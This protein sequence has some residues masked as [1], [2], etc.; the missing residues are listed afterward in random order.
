M[1]A[2]P[3]RWGLTGA[4]Q[5]GLWRRQRRTGS[6]TV[7]DAGWAA[8]LAGMA[9]LYAILGEG[10]LEHRVLVADHGGLAFGRLTS[11]PPKRVGGEEDPRYRELRAPLAR[12]RRRAAPLSRVLPDAGAGRRAPLG[13]AACGR[14][15]RPRWA[16]V[17]RMGGA[18][19]VARRGVARSGRRPATRSAFRRDESHRGA[20][21][22]VGVWR[23]SRHPNY[24]G[25]WLT[26]C[27]YALI[28]LAAP[29]GWVGLLSPALMLYL[30][31]FV[32]GDSA[33]RGAS[34]RLEGRGVPPLP[35]PDQHVRAVAA[36]LRLRW[37]RLATDLEV[38]FRS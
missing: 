22:D 33:A 29:W 15:Q 7:V 11:A 9:I 31:L 14:V 10:G 1:G 37:L 24:F 21:I 8:S 36:A 6:A 4:L 28:G 16:R 17:A 25:Q 34:A 5:L 13:S 30:I 38:E 26:W 2:A 35:A 19:G 12:A 3:A 32:T 23:F 27:G 18:R 20:V